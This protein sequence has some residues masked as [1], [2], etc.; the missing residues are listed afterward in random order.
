MTI[1][2]AVENHI[3]TMEKAGVPVLFSMERVRRMEDFGDR[4]VTKVESR[5]GRKARVFTVLHT[6]EGS[7][8]WFPLGSTGPHLTEFK[9][10]G[11]TCRGA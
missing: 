10:G 3:S 5:M 9:S 6:P 11:K 4:Q 7:V 2:E 1:R 8:G